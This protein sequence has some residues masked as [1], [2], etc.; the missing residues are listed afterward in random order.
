MAQPTRALVIIDVQNEFISRRGNFPCPEQSTESLIKNLSTLIPQFRAYG[1]QIIRVNAI[2]EDR[3]EQAAGMTGL[4]KGSD[5][6]LTNA[7]HVYH[8]SCCKK[9]SFGSRVHPDIWV[10]ADLESDVIVNKGFYSAFNG[11]AELLDQLTRKGVSDAYF[12]G[13]ASG[14]CVLASVLDATKQKD[15]FNTHVVTDCLGHRRITNHE[16]SIERMKKLPDVELVNS[17]NIEWIQYGKH[18]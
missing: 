11:T 7:T 5:E 17:D 10:H 12:C 4:V 6:W 16:E 14:T 2:Y 18:E 1:G 3:T 8:I 15:K 9:D 13:I